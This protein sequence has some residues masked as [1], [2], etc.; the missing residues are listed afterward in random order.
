MSFVKTAEPTGRARFNTIAN[1]D[2][3]KVATV[4]SK[5]TVLPAA[6]P[7]VAAG[8]GDTEYQAVCIFLLAHIYFR[9]CMCWSVSLFLTLS[10]VSPSPLSL[11]LPPS[12][13]PPP[14]R[15]SLSPVSPS[16]PSLSLSPVSPSP[17][18]L[19]QNPA[20]LDGIA[21]MSQLV[22]L[23]EDNVLHNMRCRYDDQKIYTNVAS[24]LLAVNPYESLP[25]Y[26]E[27]VMHEYR[28]KTRSELRASEPHC[29]AVAEKAYQ[30][31]AKFKQNQSMVICGESGSGKTETAKVFM[32]YLAHITGQDEEAGDAG[33]VEDQF[34]RSNPVLEAFGN[35]KTNLNNNSSRFGKFT[36]VLFEAETKARSRPGICGS[37]IETYLLEKSRVVFQERGERNYHIFYELLRGLDDETRQQWLV[38]DIEVFTYLN[39]H[40]EDDRKEV[41]PYRVEGVDDAVRFQ[42][43]RAAMSRLT[44]EDAEQMEMFAVVAAVLHLGNVQFDY[45]NDTDDDCKVKEDSKGYV[46]MAARLLQ[47]TTEALEGRLTT[48]TIKVGMQNITKPLSPE[49]AEANRDGMAKS[50][51]HGV[52]KYVVKRINNVLYQNDSQETLWIGILDVFGFES[53]AYN[54]SFEQFCI[55]FANE[56]LQKFFN[57]SVVESEQEEYMREAVPWAPV[58]IADNQDVIDLI[59][60]TPTGIVALLDAA[61]QQPKGNDAIFVHNLFQEH[62]KHMRLKIARSRR[63]SISHFAFSKSQMQ[64]LLSS[65]A[66]APAATKRHANRG[67][68]RFSG[69][70]ILHYAGKVC[71]NSTGFVAKNKD[72]GHPDTIKVM[73][74]SGNKVVT[75]LLTEPETKS[76]KRSRSMKATVGKQFLRQLDSLMKTLYDTQ[77]HYVRCMNPNQF[78]RNR[79]FD[80]EYVRPQ[81]RCGGL[82]EALRILKLGYPSRVSY[83]EIY[84]RYGH[85][86][87]KELNEK[88]FTE[89]VFLAFGMHEDDYQLGLTKVFFKPGKQEFLEDVLGDNPELTPEMI[90]KVMSLMVMKRWRRVRAGIL[91][92]VRLD[93]WVRKAR[94]LKR[95]TSVAATVCAI[96]RAF[97]GPLRKIKQ[98]RAIRSIQA[99]MQTALAKRTAGAKTDSTVAL[100]KYLRTAC[101]S[102]ALRRVIDVRVEALRV[103]RN[104][105]ATTLSRYFMDVARRAG[106]AAALTERIAATKS[107]KEHEAALA[108]EAREKAEAERLRKLE[109][110]RKAAEEEELQRQARLEAARKQQ[111][112]EEK[113]RQRQEDEAREKREQERL[114]AQAAAKAEADAERARLEKEEQDRQEA[115]A[116]KRRAEEE[117][118]ERREAQAKAKADKE[119]QFQESIARQKEEQQSQQLAELEQHLEEE[120]ASVEAK[121]PV[122]AAAAAGGSKPPPPGPPGAPAKGGKKPPPPSYPIPEHILIQHRKRKEAIARQ[123]ALQALADSPDQVG[124]QMRQMLLAGGKF[125]K[126]GKRGNPHIKHIAVNVL[127]N[128]HWA[129]DPID[130]K[131]MMP[132]TTYVKLKDVVRVVKGKTTSV[133]K[134][135]VAKK[136]PEYLCFSVVTPDRT[137]DLQAHNLEQRDLWVKALDSAVA[138]VRAGM[139]NMVTGA[140][141]QSAN[142]TPARPPPEYKRTHRLTISSASGPLAPQR[143]QFARAEEQDDIDFLE[144]GDRVI[145][146]GRTGNPKHRWLKVVGHTLCWG[147]TAT[148]NSN[149]VKL[150]EVLRIQVGKD[151][152]IFMRKTANKA[153][154]KNCFSIILKSRS[155]DFE[156]ETNEQREEWVAA[157]KLAV[158]RA[159][160]A[161]H[162]QWLARKRQ[163]SST[164]MR[165]LTGS[166][167]QTRPASMTISAGMAPRAPARARAGTSVATTAAGVSSAPRRGSVLEMSFEDSMY[168]SPMIVVEDDSVAVPLPSGDN[169]AAGDADEQPEV[170][171]VISQMARRG[172]V[173][174]AAAN[175]AKNMERR[176][177]ASIAPTDD[178]DTSRP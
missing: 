44:I 12:L 38:E 152:E 161:A 174:I 121:A 69:F 89:A 29:F 25:I 26:S 27:D 175:V 75:Q 133:M 86:M 126:Y 151:T 20:H 14:P 65:K 64:Q 55:N 11:P 138:D 91:L 113:E 7:F 128:L 167:P 116:A 88:D 111:E 43:L 158:L 21:D 101:R 129:G 58:P 110:E 98:G 147:V 99:F 85:L 22:Y 76:G 178:E 90:K 156:V 49:D 169:G 35:A 70:T 163:E 18:S 102:R 59:S 16:P 53:S 30:L 171:Q 66:P 72:V 162:D 78:K 130:S 50:L 32:R 131:K 48:R 40:P 132:S 33:T 106:L 93:R 135:S 81:L 97:S 112:E 118:R 2:E 142:Q 100:Q 77:P 96:S 9:I 165:S 46:E 23:E 143:S 82:V 10:P 150:A 124:N 120:E 4:Q 71:Y 134:R 31:M 45:V 107:R 119:R 125:L 159:K 123:K 84:T 34:L 154:E 51:Y 36:K 157:L 136:A 74:S 56:Q 13:P 83:N 79:T 160:K 153:E 105:A 63:L 87:E 15:L 24:I 60:S 114:Q 145:K 168:G 166:S 149:F 122:A 1:K 109:E 177:A 57:K 3:A 117:E 62:P 52:F 5:I 172:S 73:A 148:D 115:V 137:L 144:H 103:K 47:L 146:H 108:Q 54:N 92:L 42:E 68:E 41:D 104:T 155:V 139:I 94:V 28:G 19:P 141:D 140:R 127:G 170:A 17:P 176:R 95:L 164:Q 173:E 80:A 67:R 6:S 8:Y 37:F 61:C 39:S